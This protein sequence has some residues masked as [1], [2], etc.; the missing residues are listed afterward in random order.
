LRWENVN[1]RDNGLNSNV[2][3]HLFY[4]DYGVLIKNLHSPDITTNGMLKK[5]WEE[6]D[7]NFFLTKR[8]NYGKEPAVEYISSQIISNIGIDR[9]PYE[10]VDRG[11]I[12]CSFCPCFIT[13]NDQEF[14]PF[15]N[16]LTDLDKSQR[17]AFDVM[18]KLG[19]EQEI[20]EM[21][22]CDYIIGNVDRHS[23]NYGFIVDSET[24]SIIRMAP[25]FDHG[26]SKITEPMDA[27]TSKVGDRPFIDMLKKIDPKYFDKFTNLSPSQ[28]LNPEMNNEY[29]SQSFIADCCDA[30]ANRLEALGE[31]KL[32]L[33]QDYER[34]R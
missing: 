4:N 5:M 10:L 34:D 8:P 25:L 29:I 6:R 22:I 23:K 32:K 28:I 14:V 13:T 17:H 27:R 19:F 24:Q 7:G 26:D 21:I 1:F 11:G 2:Y 18:C 31:I 12:I 3:K 15:D 16:L 9:V 30:V 33:E 20:S